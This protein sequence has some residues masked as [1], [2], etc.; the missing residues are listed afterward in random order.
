MN[1]FI[2]GSS[3]DEQMQ[4]SHQM[5]YARGIRALNDLGCG[6]VPA[7]VAYDIL[8]DLKRV[9]HLLPEALRQLGAGLTASLAECDVYDP[10]LDPAE[11]VEMA[12]GLLTRAATTAAELAE[13]LE[14]AQSALNDQGYYLAKE[15]R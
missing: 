15:G 5:R 3:Q 14:Q 4:V 9:G 11:S 7:P 6:A 2:A 8:S 13:L 12:R 1:P 10:A